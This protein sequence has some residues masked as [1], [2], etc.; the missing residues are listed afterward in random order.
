M[1]RAQAVIVLAYFVWMARQTKRV[2]AGRGTMGAS[3]RD[4]IQSEA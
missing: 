1:T 3:A 4:E 2:D